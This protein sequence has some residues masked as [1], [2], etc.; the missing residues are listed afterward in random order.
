MSSK[1]RHR[2]N[3]DRSPFLF[4]VADRPPLPTELIEWPED[5]AAAAAII[6]M[7]EKVSAQHRAL[8]DQG[9]DY[10]AWQERT[11]AMLKA[12]LEY[13]RAHPG[14]LNGRGVY[15]DNYRRFI[16]SLAH[17]L[18]QGMSLLKL[19]TA[20]GVEEE[21]LDQWLSDAGEPRT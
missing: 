3:P 17:G 20:T 9:H 16:L 15:T 8:E 14:E 2:R 12:V 18:G 6:A 4:V 19:S 21:V 7:C 10:E 11:S 1:R 5:P 13:E